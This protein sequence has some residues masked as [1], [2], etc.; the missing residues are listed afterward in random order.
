VTLPLVV[1]WAIFA[2]YFVAARGVRNF[3]PL[4][5]FDMYQRRAPAAVSRVLVIDRAGLEHAIADF[6]AFHCEPA[7]P[8][9][10]DVRR[11]CGPD[12][13]PLDYVMRDLQRDLDAHLSSEPGTEEIAIVSRSF[14][15][16]PAGGAMTTADC[17]L[18]RCTARARG[19]GP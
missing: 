1:A 16:D 2:A 6:A 5:V 18:A 3:F 11:Y 17:V 12:H 19:D 4:S 13:V 14:R 10:T 8:M 15:L 7:P 9:L